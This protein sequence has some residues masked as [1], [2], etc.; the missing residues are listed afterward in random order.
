M[1]HDMAQESLGNHRKCG[2]AANYLA[3]SGGTPKAFA[4]RQAN[5]PLQPGFQSE[6]KA[7]YHDES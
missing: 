4:S 2:E 6:A 3:S 1:P 7:V 5:L